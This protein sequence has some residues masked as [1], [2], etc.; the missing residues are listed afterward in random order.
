MNEDS[1]LP[2][3]RHSLRGVDHDGH[4]VVL[5]AS[6]SK[7]LYRCPGCRRSIP[8]GTDHVI[9]EFPDRGAEAFHQHWH[10][11]CA[12]E[13]IVRQLRSIHLVPASNAGKP[14]RGQRRAATLK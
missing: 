11:V 5:V 7:E 10:R 12:R 3:R 14:T 8:V 4:K 9:V 2:S 6:I 13:G 1:S